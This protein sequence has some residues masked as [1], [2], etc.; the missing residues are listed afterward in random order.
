[1]NLPRIIGLY[2]DAP[3]CGKTTVATYLARHNYRRISFAEPLKEM[4]AALLQNLG[5]SPAAA[6]YRV[7]HEKNARIPEIGVTVRHLL[8]TLGT[9]WGRECL[10]PEVWLISWKHRAEKVLAAGHNVV[11]DD[12]RFLNEAE[13]LR[14]L[15]GDLWRITRPGIAPVTTHSSEG[16]LDHYTFDFTIHNN[17][18]LRTLQLAVCQKLGVAHI[19]DTNLDLA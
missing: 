2:S 14:T 5:Y 11:V 15:G 13:L 10:H 1:M 3:Q 8:Q 16:G 6:L 19:P 7:H 12:V 18:S 4:A 9:E 17:V